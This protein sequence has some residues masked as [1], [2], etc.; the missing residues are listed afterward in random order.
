[1]ETDPEVLREIAWAFSYLSDGN[2]DRIQLLVDTDIIPSL[3][4]HI[5]H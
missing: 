1:M 4:K 3:I 2:E 5:N